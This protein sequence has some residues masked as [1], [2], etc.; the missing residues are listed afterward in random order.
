MEITLKNK[1]L[2]QAIAFLQSLKLKN[3]DSRHRS[4]FVKLLVKA[5]E[6][7]AEEEANLLKKYDLLDENGT[8]KQD[9]EH[10]HEFKYEQAVLYEE[11]VMISG[12]MYTKNIDEL[13]RILNE[14]DVELDGQ[15]AEIYDRLLD[16]ME[17]EDAE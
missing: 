15:Q 3:A 9:S 2:A 16:E 5:Y 10:A 8:I 12:G 11:E 7:L 6:E 17:K 1:E 4:K 14:I 13:P